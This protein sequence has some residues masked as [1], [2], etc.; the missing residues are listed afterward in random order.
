LLAVAAGTS[1]FAVAALVIAMTALMQQ[2]SPQRK[3]ATVVTSWEDDP[4][5]VVP[6]DPI[7]VT[8]EMAR[9]AR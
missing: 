6:S 9:E 8:A 1:A 4:A 3:S 5:I 7:P 2:D